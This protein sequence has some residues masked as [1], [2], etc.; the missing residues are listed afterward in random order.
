M[1]LFAA[2]LNIPSAQAAPV[3][4][5]AWVEFALYQ[6]D[7]AT[8]LAD[9]SW[10]FIIGSGDG[11]ADPMFLY[12]GTNYIA[13]T[14]TG[15]DVILGMVRIGANGADPGTFFTTVRYESDE[16]NYVY[17]RFF[18]T[19]GEITGMQNWGQSATFDLSIMAGVTTVDFGSGYANQQNNFVVIPE[20]STANLVV[21]IAGMVWAMRR[22]R[23]GSGSGP[24]EKNGELA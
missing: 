8:P 1:A 6:S 20:P 18:E 21:L 17:I 13:Q 5:D 9:G 4:L 24:D 16:I 15:D 7:N 11:V 14:V 10:V 12:G 23:R 2:L 19:G 3:D 22:N